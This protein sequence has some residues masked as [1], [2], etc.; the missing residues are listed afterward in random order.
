[1][2]ELLRAV[3]ISMDAANSNTLKVDRN[4]A[5]QSSRVKET[6]F[7]DRDANRSGFKCRI[8]HSARGNFC[9]AT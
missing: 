4:S 7:P 6:N 2:T 5:N 3:E 1:M 8:V 9:C